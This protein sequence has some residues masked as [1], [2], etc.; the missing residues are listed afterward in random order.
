MPYALPVLLVANKPT[1]L[2]REMKRC[3]GKLT[4]TG[5]GVGA[6]RVGASVAQVRKACHIP[7]PRLKKGE[8]PPPDDL[9]EF[10]IGPTPVQAQI[11]DGRVWRIVIDGPLLTTGD[12]LGVGS[13]VAALLAAGPARAS[14]GEGVIYASLPGRCGLIFQLSYRPRRGEDRDAWTPDT[15]ALLPANTT[16]ERVMISG[17]R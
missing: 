5:D 2:E 4:L 14:Q 10:K 12:R 7:K 13:P 9:L 1:P 15:L 6:L 8:R 17:C 3:A 16:I 11:E